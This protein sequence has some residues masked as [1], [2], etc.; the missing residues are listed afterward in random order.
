MRVAAPGTI[1]A[2]DPPGKAARGQKQHRLE[3]DPVTAPVVAW[4]FAEYLD[5]SGLSTIGQ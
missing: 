2:L 3:L 4:I 1:K 5:G